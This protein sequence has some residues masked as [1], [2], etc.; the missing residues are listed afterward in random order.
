MDICGCS[1][2]QFPLINSRIGN[3]HLKT[4]SGSRLNETKAQSQKSKK[5]NTE[6]LESTDEAITKVKVTYTENNEIETKDGKTETTKSP[7]AGNTYIVAFADG[8]LKC[9]T[10]DG[11]EVLG[12]A[13]EEL[14]K[15]QKSLGKPDKLSSFISGKELKIGQEITIPPEAMKDIF[16]GNDEIN[17]E[18]SSATVKLLEI[19]KKDGLTLAKFE[20]KLTL[21]GTPSPEMNMILAMTGTL[22][23]DTSTSWPI[24]MT[25]TGPVTIS[26]GNEQFSMDGKG[27]MTMK[28]EA[29]YTN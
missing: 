29:S 27:T 9:T 5:K 16:E 19:L 17:K 6:V 13:L 24:D 21:V 18:K 23:V 10:E 15:D 7:L 22:T 25:L 14:K 11:K 8:E 28:A 1:K 20:F 4:V 3:V 12:E 2:T 26:G